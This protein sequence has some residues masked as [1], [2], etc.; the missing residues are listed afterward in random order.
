MYLDTNNP[1]TTQ[2]TTYSVTTGVTLYAQVKG[3]TGYAN[4]A[5]A[6]ATYT[7]SGGSAFAYVSAGGNHG[8]TGN[9]AITYSPTTGNLVVV[10]VYEYNSSANPPT[11]VSD[12]GTS[13]GC[14]YSAAYTAKNF[15]AGYYMV[16]Y[17]CLS[18]VASTTTIT[19]AAGTGSGALSANIT[20]WHRASGSW[21]HDASASSV[22]TGATS[23]GGG[24]VATG[25]SVTPTSGA[26]EVI[27][28]QFIN[29]S[30]YTTNWATSGSWTLYNN[31]EDV[32]ESTLNGV[33]GQIVTSTSG[34][35][36][37]L[38]S[39]GSTAVTYYGMSTTY[40]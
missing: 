30:N 12:N 16:E 37:P 39:S 27:I 23:S 4:S 18:A 6:S 8:A 11:G 26:P 36:S 22:A 25:A 35:Y 28:G 31:E 5:I 34:S 17:Y 1:P 32:V 15:Y 21:V 3:C 40:K 13:G 38:A 33:T 14:S 2:Q 7:I 29:F 10:D 20:E 9:L 19:V 24:Y